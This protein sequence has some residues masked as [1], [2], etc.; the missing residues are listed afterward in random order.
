M[1]SCLG[2]PTNVQFSPDGR[3]LAILEMDFDGLLI[4][5][6]DLTCGFGRVK[7][8]QSLQC[9][10][11]PLH[12][13][14]FQETCECN[15]GYTGHY[16]ACLA[17]APGTYKEVNGSSPCLLCS[18]GKYST[19]TGEP[20]ELAC[21][22]CRANSLSEAGSVNIEKCSCNQGYFRAV[23]FQVL[24]AA[25]MSSVAWRF[26]GE[27]VALTNGKIYFAPDVVAEVGVLD[28]TTIPET[29]SV[30][31][32]SAHMGGSNRLFNGAVRSPDNKIIMVPNKVDKIG[33]LDPETDEFGL[34]DMTIASASTEYFGGGVLGRDDN[35]YF[36]P[37]TSDEIGVLNPRTQEFTT[38]DISGTIASNKK[39]FGGAAHGNGN[40]YFCPANAN[41]VSM[42]LCILQ[43]CVNTEDTHKLRSQT[44]FSFGNKIC[45][46]FRS[47]Y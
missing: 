17:C 26:A 6:V 47:E 15:A 46:S 20:S 2:R 41:N 40:I 5:E 44:H 30:R 9:M 35:I 8:N 45:L 18:R 39:Y 1:T 7:Q 25:A 32:I 29:F 10:P 27:P 42:A 23:R 4:A 31:D 38:I 3:K 34:I 43:F 28:T 19:K 36:V 13:H 24:D 16:S 22:N 11:C 33:V 37:Y 21:R 14:Y 12:S